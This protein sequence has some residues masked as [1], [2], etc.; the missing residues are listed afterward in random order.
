M[1]KFLQ[2][3][4]LTMLLVLVAAPAWALGLGQLQVKSKLGEPLLAEIPVI[5]ANP[6][7]LENL[8]ARLAAPETFLRVGLPL[9]DKMVSDLRF[10]LVYDG[11]GNPFIQVTSPGPVGM[12]MMTF[13]L[14]VDWG[15]GRL[16]REYSVLLA[17]PEAVAAASQ[18]VIQ[19]PVAAP[20][21][22]IVRESAPVVAAA[23]AVPESPAPTP[24]PMAAPASPR[25]VAPATPPPPPVAPAPTAAAPIIASVAPI[26]ATSTSSRTVMTG[27]TLSAVAAQVRSPG[28]SIN[29][30]MAALLRANP[31]AFINNDPNLL[32]SGAAL[33][34]PAADAI[35]QADQDGSAAA[36]QEQLAGWRSARNRSVE[37]IDVASAS[38]VEV[39]SAPKPAPAA[40]TRRRARG[41]RLE[42]MPAT[43]SAAAGAGTRSGT[44]GEGDAEMT[45]Q[46][47]E[48]R[49]TIATR[50]AEVAE[51]KSRVAELETLQQQ[52]AQLVQMKDGQL[53]AAQRQLQQRQ[54]VSAASAPPPTADGSPWLLAAMIGLPLL[55]VL[56][57]GA[58]WM[59][60]RRPAD[61]Q[62]A[63]PSFT[64]APPPPPPKP[65]KP[66]LSESRAPLFPPLEGVQEDLV[67]APPP[68]VEPS[69]LRTPSWMGVDAIAD[70]D[71]PARTVTQPSTGWSM[72]TVNAGP[73]ETLAES[74]DTAFRAPADPDSQAGLD[75]AADTQ[76]NHRAYTLPPG[77]GV[78]DSPDA[79]SEAEVPVEAFGVVE[80]ERLALARTYLDLD[81]EATARKLLQEVI[82][83][84]GPDAAQARRMLDGIDLP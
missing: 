56:G 61:V 18:P 46:L 13:L 5:S 47:Q 3:A 80:D 27:D 60:R 1:K 78:F 48:A 11:A 57:L 84:G 73:V 43:A 29:A 36:L 55:I 19:A 41:A 65:A 51:L 20:S 44:G 21:N 77:R 24:A 74:Q 64:K 9:P 31:D 45:Q 83:S 30:V 23:P 62:G 75:I 52:Q 40:T 79:A 76:S 81:D 25:P 71:D 17:E 42:I 34:V 4:V 70:K 6:A 7:E 2:A 33:N 15:D 58:W 32:R 63:E 54:Q 59:R 12:P 10:A 50:D 16:V 66:R 69:K 72:P 38:E 53:A 26:A 22:A 8:Q 82:S 37:A 35:N 49:E 14:E 68:A 28:Q 67:P 39:A